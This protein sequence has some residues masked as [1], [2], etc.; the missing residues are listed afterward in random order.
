MP[1][2]TTMKRVA[3]ELGVSIT[4]VSKVLN[5]RSDIGDATR[6]RVLAKVAELGYQPNAVA[7]SLTLRRTRTL[8]I[9][10][11]DLMH[12]FFVEIVAGIESIARNRGYGLLLCSSNEDPRKE[13]EEV[14][15]LRQRQVDGVVLASVNAAGNTDLLQD[16]ASHG[17]GLVMIDRDD[18]AAV[19]CDRVVTDDDEV[20]LHGHDAPA[21]SGAHGHR[22]HRR[23]RHRPR[24][25]AD[26]RIPGGAAGA[27]RPAAAGMDPS[28]RVHGS[29]RLPGDEEAPGREDARRRRLRRQRSGGD[30]RDEGDLGRQDA[31]VPDDVAV[32]G[33][34]DIALGDLL[35]VPL[36]TV[37]WSRD[38]LG[39]RAAELH[40]SKRIDPSPPCRVQARRH[41]APPGRAPLERWSGM[42]A[43]CCCRWPSSPRARRRRSMPRPIERARV[44]AAAD[45]YLAEP[46]VTVTASSLSAQ[47]RRPHDYFSEGDYWW[48]DPENPGGPYLQRDGLTNPEQ[49]RRAPPSAH[50]PAPSGAGARRG[51][52]ADPRARATRRTPRATCA[53]GSSTTATRMN[54]HL[55]YAQAIQGRV[56]GRGIGI[57]DTLHLVEVARAHRGARDGSGRLAPRTTRRSAAG[58][59]TT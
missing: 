55:R 47:R 4:T 53:P 8:G 36:T 30:R 13:R 1:P 57:I 50:A 48:P 19:R 42:I 22:P 32:V 43:S 20:G 27:R 29:G 24:A 10:I 49:L 23:A 59:R 54:P 51:L 15:I 3:D 58:S 34:G 46:P 6:A 14:E 5:N 7:R 35:R 44:L 2:P 21:G 41:P 52:P 17:I 37:S 26:G 56:T 31:C 9:I 33:A 40:L 25:A 11:P 45:R 39:K 18:H 16:L 12:S 38:D 28:R